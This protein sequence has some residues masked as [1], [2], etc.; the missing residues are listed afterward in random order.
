V[1]TPVAIGAIAPHGDLAIAAACDDATRQLAT[2]T[3]SAMDD[4]ARR[5][6]RS[7]ADTV[8]VATPHGVHVAGHIAV[9][10]AGSAAGRLDDA[11]QPLELTVALDA[12][13][14]RAVST[15]IAAAGVPVVGVSYGGNSSAEAV[16]PL[17]WGALIPLW[18]VRRH[19]PELPAVIVSPARELDAAAHVEAGAAIARAARDASRRIAFIASADQGHGHDAD[20]RYGFRAES[21]VFDSR[22]AGIVRRG[23]LDELLDITHD[24]VSAALADSWWQMLM[25]VGAMRE[26]GAQYDCDLL[27]YEAPTYYGMLTAVVTPRE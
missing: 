5:I 3:Q 19:G 18:H 2:A 8:V 15:T 16:M 12:E 21:A 13:L 14:A 20:G 4:V 1:P 25:L 9:V 7:G 6:A 26:N 10:T 24:Q 17:D 22:V 23:T 11:P 27:A